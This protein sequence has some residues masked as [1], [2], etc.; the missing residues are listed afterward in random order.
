MSLGFGLEMPGR[1]GSLNAELMVPSSSLWIWGL[2]SALI[3]AGH[4]GACPPHCSCTGTT[5]DCHGLTFKNVPR[6]IPKNTE[7]L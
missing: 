4:S 3:L 6:N 2:L 1:T 7:R 5:V